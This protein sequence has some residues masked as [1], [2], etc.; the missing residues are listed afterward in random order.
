MDITYLSYVVA[1]VLF[2]AFFS[3][4]EIAYISSNKLQI[5]LQ[6]KQGSMTG[7]ILSRFVNKP[8]QFIGTTLIGNTI[9][10]VLYGIFMA[11]L[12]EPI[13][14]NLLPPALNNDAVVLVSQ[15][16]LSTLIV[17]I[18][19]EF[20]PKSFFMLNPNNM[21]TIFAV[22]FF[23]IYVLMYPIVWL[24]VGLSRIFITKVLRLEYN[25]EKPVFTITDLNSYIRQL[26]SN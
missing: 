23:V 24:T 25:E 10:L 6:N 2:S 14:K 9:M 4:M 22:P 11:F 26:R 16:F 5:E 12:L 13:L 17:L 21:M 7:R 19:G 18:T 20:L 1:I 15:T 3:G 8:G